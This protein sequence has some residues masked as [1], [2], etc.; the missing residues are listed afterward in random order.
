MSETLSISGLRRE[1][2]LAGLRRTDLEANP[3]VQFAKWFQ[4]A[5]TAKLAE[6]NAMT[7]ATVDKDGCPSS[8]IVLLKGTDARGFLFFSNYN[9]R[10]GREL[11]GNPQAAI[12]L[13]WA[14]LERQVC[15]AGTTSKIARDES[16]AYFNSRPKGSR[17]SAWV[18]SQS[19]TIAD[20]EVLE[21]KLREFSEKFPNDDVSLPPYWGGYCLAPTRIEF[22]QG[23]PDRLH[24]RFE[25]S[26]QSDGHWTIQRLSP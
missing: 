21:K 19:E 15:I 24:D 3:M 14:E 17:L 16:A 11:A 5:Q 1:Y 20:R 6:P 12:V 8:R 26:K 10:K 2:T 22:W 9:S 4:Q 7:L 18:S 25:Y 23:R 13:Y